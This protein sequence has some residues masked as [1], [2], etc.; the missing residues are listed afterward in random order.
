MISFSSSRLAI[1]AKCAHPQAAWQFLS[2]T[3]T[4]DSHRHFFGIPVLQ[5]KYE[6]MIAEAMEQN[7]Y[8][9]ENGNKVEQ[10]KMGIGYEDGTH[11]EIFAAKPEEAALFRELVDSAQGRIDYDEKVMQIILEDCAPYFAG[12]KTARETAQVIQSR[13]QTYISENR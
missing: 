2:G 3:L 12:Q 6:E 4:Q 10:S 9:D 8:T 5:E 1:S 11:I 13:V 7:F